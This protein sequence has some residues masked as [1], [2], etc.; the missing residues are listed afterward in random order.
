[1]AVILQV[2][3][4]VLIAELSRSLELIAEQGVDVLYRGELGAKNY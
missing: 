2:A 3:D 4:R 1:M